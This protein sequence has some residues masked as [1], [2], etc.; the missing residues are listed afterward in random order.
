MVWLVIGNKLTVSPLFES[1]QRGIL[2][3]RF[4]TLLDRPFFSVSIAF[5]SAVEML[6]T[7][8]F[9]LVAI[10]SFIDHKFHMSM[11][12]KPKHRLA[13]CGHSQIRQKK[14]VTVGVTS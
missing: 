7:S 6:D 4:S 12:S 13:E 10:L 11:L 8:V 9:G 5:S 3:F 2:V 1:S 14:L